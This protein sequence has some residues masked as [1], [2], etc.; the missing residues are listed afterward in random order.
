MNIIAAT[1]FAL[2][3]TF[4]LI[5]CGN[6]Q[7]DSSAIQRADI[8]DLPTPT[9][10][11]IFTTS[12]ETQ[13]NPEDSDQAEDLDEFQGTILQ[14]VV[15][16][17]PEVARL[18]RRVRSGQATEEE[19]ERL[20]AMLSEQFG[21]PDELGPLG[22]DA[23]P[24]FGS[25]ESVQADSIAIK[26][27][28]DEQGLD[29]PNTTITIAD[30]TE[31]LIASEITQADLALNET[32]DVIATRDEDGIITARTITI[33]DF[34]ELISD[35][36]A[37]AA[38]G[39][40]SFSRALRIGRLLG[41]GQARPPGLGAPRLGAAVGGAGPAGPGQ[42]RPGRGGLGARFAAGQQP[43]A[44]SNNGAGPTLMLGGDAEGIPAQGRIT[45]IEDN[46][47]HIETEQGPL[48][49]NLN[50]QTALVR[51]SSGQTT[52]ITEDQSAWA[53]ATSEGNALLLLLGP[54]HI[55]E[56][57]TAGLNSPVP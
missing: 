10:G 27:Y 57:Q 42:G 2:A 26:P 53:L 51:I 23:Q 41:G 44:D 38:G 45:K 1:A 9:G 8:A 25:I 39:R 28:P 56:L 12:E 37:E 31:I 54:Q 33:A 55:L 47:L 34:D 6:S 40:P 17:N 30:D 35:A 14:D 29:L 3:L 36:D 4:A 21:N 16:E 43:D 20:F 49:V 7:S 46:R 22:F 18:A 15:A 24:I 5:A 11:E 13:T 32:V 52:D 50:D 19:T 48:R